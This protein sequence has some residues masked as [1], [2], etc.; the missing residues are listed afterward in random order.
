VGEDDVEDVRVALAPCVEEGPSCPTGEVV[1]VVDGKEVTVFELGGG[2][3]DRP[4]VDVVVAR[5]GIPGYDGDSTVDA[6]MVERHLAVL[7]RRRG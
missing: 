7:H 1:Q 2:P 5:T 4:M 3:N 6:S